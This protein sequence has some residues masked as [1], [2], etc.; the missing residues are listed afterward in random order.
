MTANEEG[1]AR[2]V[3]VRTEEILFDMDGTLVDS[4]PAVEAAW[5]EWA[6]ARNIT[7]P[8][9]ALLHGRTAED[10][11]ATFVQP[12]QIEEAASQL[13]RIE[14]ES[15]VLLEPVRGAREFLAELPE[16]R[17]AVV[18][19]AA[20][21][22]SRTRLRNGGIA[23]PTHWITGDEVERGK[24][25]P[26]PFRKG[27]RYTRSAVAFEDTVAGIISAKGAG[28]YTVGVVG[29]LGVEE[30]SRHADA[31]IEDYRS[32]S[33]SEWDGAEFTLEICCV[34]RG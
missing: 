10:F 20:R 14:T 13:C 28:C 26:E 16:G 34:R 24:P 32:V 6:D 33:V 25:D 27:R 4:I 3:R 17:W 29:T 18:T 1:R 22:V 2:S 15:G 8:D 12:E 23:P 5:Q 11:V 21:E 19:S 7:L 31:V 30:L 9:V